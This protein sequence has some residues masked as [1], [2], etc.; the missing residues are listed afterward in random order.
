MPKT[1]WSFET[2]AADLQ[3]G[4]H[5]MHPGWVLPRVRGEGLWS[6]LQFTKADKTWQRKINIKSFFDVHIR[7]PCRYFD[8]VNKNYVIYLT[9]KE[10]K[11]MYYTVIKHD[12]NLRTLFLRCS[13]ISVV[14]YDSIIHGFGF[15]V[16]LKYR[17]NACETIKHAFL[18]FILW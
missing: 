6:Q 7:I 18:R 12:G 2:H 9:N 8:E 3:H 1:T 15:F 13:Q 11:A 10:A 4:L 5:K 17:F 16:C 14:F